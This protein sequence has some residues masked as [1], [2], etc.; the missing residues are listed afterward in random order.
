MVKNVLSSSDRSS[1][2]SYLSVD[3][4]ILNSLGIFYFYVDRVGR[5]QGFIRISRLTLVRLI[6]PEGGSLAG[7][8]RGW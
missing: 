5:F 4:Y 3:V 1:C 8:S 6:G 7:W 2:F